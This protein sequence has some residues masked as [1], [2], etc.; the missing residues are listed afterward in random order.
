[1][2]VI[3]QYGTP[4]LLSTRAI[5]TLGGFPRE[6][7]IESLPRTQALDIVG[8]AV[9]PIIAAQILAPFASGR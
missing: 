7:P 3:D 6:Y 1:M 5:A 2:R 8:N 9:P 4:R